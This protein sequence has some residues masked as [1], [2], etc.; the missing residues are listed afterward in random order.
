M[1][2]AQERSLLND[3]PRRHKGALRTRPPGR[4]FL[5]PGVATSLGI[6]R[7]A[8]TICGRIG[9]SKTSMKDPS[10]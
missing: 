7:L 1:P 9:A 10:Y 3:H 5:L 4:F 8:A 6:C 2:E